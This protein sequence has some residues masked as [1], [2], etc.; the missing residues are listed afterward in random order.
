M[1]STDRLIF[2]EKSDVRAR[3]IEYAKDYDEVHIVIFQNSKF[4]IPKLA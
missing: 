4:Q 1:I 3:Q 2:D